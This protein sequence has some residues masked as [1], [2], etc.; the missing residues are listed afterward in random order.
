MTLDTCSLL[1]RLIIGL[2]NRSESENSVTFRV[3]KKSPSSQVVSVVLTQPCDVYYTVS[4]WQ[5]QYVQLCILQVVCATSCR[6]FMTKLDP[7]ESTLTKPLEVCQFMR[8]GSTGT[9]VHS[10]HSQHST[11]LLSICR[12]QKAFR[13]PC[14]CLQFPS[15]QSQCLLPSPWLTVCPRIY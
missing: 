13:S 7:Q 9:H 8:A 1:E 3:Y 10:K 11:G 15:V 6:P 12:K 14:F 5:Y 4:C 2:Y